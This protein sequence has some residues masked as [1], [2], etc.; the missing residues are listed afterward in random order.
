[1]AA[2]IVETSRV[3]V[4]GAV[5]FMRENLISEDLAVNRGSVDGRH[6]LSRW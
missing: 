3:F 4:T 6:L 5:V 2:N 1:M